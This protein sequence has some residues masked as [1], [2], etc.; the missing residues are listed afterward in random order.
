MHDVLSAIPASCKGP[1]TQNNNKHVIASVRMQ[2]SFELQMQS[3]LFPLYFMRPLKHSVACPVYLLM[4]GAAMASTAQAQPYCGHV[5]SLLLQH[6]R[7]SLDFHRKAD[8]KL[9]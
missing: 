6:R 8:V 4:A 3:S 2:H 7:G 9:I 1:C 5:V